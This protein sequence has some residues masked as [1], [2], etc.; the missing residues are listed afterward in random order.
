MTFSTPSFPIS[1]ASST[2]ASTVAPVRLA[3]ST[4]SPRWSAWPW[5]SRMT[6]GSISSADAAAFGF[7]VRNGSVSTVVPP[8]RS[9]KQDCPRNR[10]STAI[11]HVLRLVVHES[12][13][14]LVPDCD[15]DEHAHSRLLV[16]EVADGGEPLVG[17]RPAGRAQ[18]LRFVGAVE[19]ARRV[20]GLVEDALELRGARRDDAL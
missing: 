2:I 9:S 13:S 20:H 12:M 19:P 6:S 3:M 7:P 15:A 8:A 17:V 18:H 16:D 1:A 14:Q 4:V 11:S 10:M 5:V